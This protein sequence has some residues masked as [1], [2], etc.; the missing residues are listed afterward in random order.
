[1]AS[2]VQFLEESQSPLSMLEL[3]RREHLPAANRRSLPRVRGSFRVRGQ[4]EVYTGVDLSFGGMMC[5]GEAPL[6][7]GNTV[8]LE[9]DLGDGAAPFSVKS[10][11]VELVS[12]RG[13]VGMRVRFENLDVAAGRRIATWM[14]ESRGR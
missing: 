5:L 3:P 10:R 9:V 12:Y 14:A 11:V 8:A 7:P 1:M 4:S 2:I 13:Q 6:W